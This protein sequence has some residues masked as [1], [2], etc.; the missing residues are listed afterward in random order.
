[1]DSLAIFTISRAE[2]YGVFLPRWWQALATLER[3]PDQIVIVHHESNLA[4]VPE[5][6]PAEYASRVKLVGTDA[7]AGFLYPNLCVQ[8][9][10]TD[11]V[12]FCGLDDQVLPNAYDELAECGAEILVG[13]LRLSNG[14]ESKGSWDV[15]RLRV[16]NTLP[17]LSPFRKSLWERVGGW[18]HVYWG[19]WGFWMKCAIGGATT[20]R[21]DNFQALFDLGETHETES[22]RL[23][24]SETRAAANAEIIEFAREIG[25]VHA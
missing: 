18:P 9:A 16:E 12:A 15:G 21:S 3:Q 2:R 20:L 14:G 4:R 8:A 5:S 1:M 13:N 22:G 19:D 24:D 6:V 17:A 11:W 23:L 10:D 7:E 25:F